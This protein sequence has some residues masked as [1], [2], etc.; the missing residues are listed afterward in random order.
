[1]LKRSRRIWGRRC[2]RSE[3]GR[4]LV[5]LSEA[6]PSGEGSGAAH[7]LSGEEHQCFGRFL[8]RHLCAEG[9][10]RADRL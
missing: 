9:S 7:F 1:M 2:I 6:L 3:N 5:D 4:I 10:A 8:H